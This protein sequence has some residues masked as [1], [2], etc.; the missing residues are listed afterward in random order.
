MNFLN[1]KQVKKLFSS[2]P[3][4]L[5]LNSLTLFQKEKKLFLV[6]KAAASLVDSSLQVR[7]IGLFLGTLENKQVILSPSAK[8]MLE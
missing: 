6:T 3:H 2:I 7:S 4:S 1:N 8:A 5:D